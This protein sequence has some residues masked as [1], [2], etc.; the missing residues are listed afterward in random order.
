MKF[1]KARGTREP[2]DEARFADLIDASVDDVIREQ[3]RVG[4]DVVNDGEFPRSSY[5]FYV[6]DRLGGFEMRDSSNYMLPRYAAV[7]AGS[8]KPT[9]Q[10][11]RL[12]FDDFYRTWDRL[13]K[14]MWMPADLQ[15]ASNSGYPREVAVCTGPIQ[16][17]GMDELKQDLNR[18]TRALTRVDT[19]GAFVTAASP[20]LTAYHFPDNEYYASEEEYL[21][22]LADALNV[23]YRAIT[24]A[25][26]VLQIDSPELCHLY[27]PAHVEEYLR[28]LGVRVEAINHALRGVPE[29]QARLHICWGSRNAPHVTDVPLSLIV[30]QMF[31]VKTQGYSLEG[32][33]DR[34]AHEVLLWDEIKLPEGKILMPGVVGHV[35]N[36]VEHPELV[37]WRISL[38]AERVGKENVIASADCGYSQDW[39]LPRVHPQV[40]WAKLQA[41][42]EGARLASRRLWRG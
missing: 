5:A 24:D 34:H 3:A 20:S 27:D 22:A 7:R 21:F 39:D 8:L 35:S 28:W 41:L 12:D 2:Y 29:E 30:D 37:A 31:R 42:S 40:Q 18:L 19:R 4:I 26:F 36:I 6:R 32:A 13:E 16:Y 33:N 15:S 17:V 25:G 38:Y 23:E 14:S 1:Q 11:E 9:S 10:R